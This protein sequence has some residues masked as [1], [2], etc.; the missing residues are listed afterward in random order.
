NLR[1]DLRA[2]ADRLDRVMR[3]VAEET[4]GPRTSAFKVTR[5][6]SE[7]SVA[8][9]RVTAISALR[10]LNRQLEVLV[11]RLEQERQP[12]AGGVHGPG[13]PPPEGETP[14]RSK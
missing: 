7:R 11:D 9:A 8:E 14:S 2:A 5:E 10:S 6:V 12:G 1:D 13:E 4:E 3:R